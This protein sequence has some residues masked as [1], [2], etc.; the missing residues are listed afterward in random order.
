MHVKSVCGSIGLMMV[1]IL[2]GCARVSDG[3][4]R[5]TTSVSPGSTATVAGPVALPESEPRQRISEGYG[6][7]VLVDDQPVAPGRSAMDVLRASTPVETAYG[8]GFVAG[9]YGRVSSTKPRRDWMYFVNGV[10]PGVGAADYTVRPGDRIW[11]DFRRWD[12]TTPTLPVIVGSWPEPFVHGYPA[13]PAS[14]QA[15]APLDAVLSRQG[16]RVS[17]RPSSWRVI[18]GANADLVAR[19][20]AWRRALADPTAAGLPVR[21]DGGA[22]SV[23]AVDGGRMR[24]VAGAGAVAAMVLSNAGPEQ[25][26]VVFVVAGVDRSAAI[27]AARAIAAGPALLAGQ[28]AVVFDRTGRPLASAGHAAP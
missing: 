17:S 18:V 25:G 27:A 23:M 9:M 14:V 12:D 5:S 1:M 13:A 15:D 7:T 4:S 3:T 11:W 24:P 8:G 2:G 21:I 16:V 20:A 19:D 6:A 10:S 28:V 26:G 22:I